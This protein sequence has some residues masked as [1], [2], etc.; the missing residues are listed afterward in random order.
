MGKKPWLALSVLVLAGLL[1]GGCRNPNSVSPPPRT[2]GPI[3]NVPSTG[4]PGGAASNQKSVQGNGSPFGQPNSGVTPATLSNGNPS[5]GLGSNSGNLGMGQGAISPA[6][7][8]IGSFSGLGGA[9]PSPSIPGVTPNPAGPSS[10]P[11]GLSGPAGAPILP[12]PP[13][14][15]GFETRRTV[16]PPTSQPSVPSPSEVQPAI[17]GP[18]TASPRL[19]G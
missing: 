12:D 10:G 1:A 8:G 18:T 14:S 16:Y 15:S 6:A 3:P 9:G 13:Q 11:G 2:P 4:I 5:A 7:P 17:N 19:G